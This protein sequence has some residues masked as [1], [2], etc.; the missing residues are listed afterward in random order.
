M[1]PRPFL[2]IDLGELPDE[3]ESL[4]QAAH[5]AN[6]ACGGHAGDERSMA[7]AL[8]RCRRHGTAAGAHPSYVDRE[9]FGRRRLEIAPGDLTQAVHLQCARLAEAAHRVSL[10]IRHVKPHGA[11]YHAAHADAAV[12]R[13][14]IEG[15]VA[16]LGRDLVVLGPAGGALAEAARAAGLGY[17][18]ESFADRATRADGSLVP[19]DQPGALITDAAAAAARAWALAQAGQVDTLCVHGDTPGAEAIARAVREALDEGDGYRRAKPRPG[20]GA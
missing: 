20:D 7:L 13:A 1:S 5:L 14:V 3:P 10:P 4:Y 2:N 12:A 17:A 16:A 15:A 18:V 9:G 11:L 6:I 19:R 8:D